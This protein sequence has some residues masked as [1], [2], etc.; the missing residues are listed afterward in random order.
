MARLRDAL[1]PATLIGELA[2]TGGK[3]RVSICVGPERIISCERN[4]VV[5]IDVGNRTQEIAVSRVKLAGPALAA[6]ES[7]ESATR[8]ASVAERGGGTRKTLD[9]F[10][11][12]YSV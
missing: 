9:D 4:R 3:D 12:T 5:E 2:K 7:R 6:D 1:P 11:A 10:S 8:R